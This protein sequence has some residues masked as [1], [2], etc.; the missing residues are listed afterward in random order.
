[1]LQKAAERMKNLILAFLIASLVTNFIVENLPDYPEFR[2]LTIRGLYSE[3]QRWPIRPTALRSLRWIIPATWNP[4]NG[5]HSKNK[6][7][8]WITRIDVE[9]QKVE[10]TPL[11]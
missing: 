7:E 10:I 9:Y 6:K 11:T 2:D 3:A 4:G 1:M 8:I 5:L